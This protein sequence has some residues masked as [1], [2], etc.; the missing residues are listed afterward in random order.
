M[1]EPVKTFS[2]GFE[3]DAGVRRNR[4]RAARP[5]ERFGT[6]HTEFRVQPSAIDLLDTLIWHHDG[7]FGDS[8]AIP[9][10]LVSQAD[11]RARHRR[12][13][14]RRRRRSVCR[15]PAVRRRDCRRSQCPA[16]AAG[17]AVT[18]LP[19]AAGL[20]QRAA[21]ESRAA[22]ASR[23]SCSCRWTIG[24]RAWTGVFFDDLERLLAGGSSRAAPPS[25]ARAHLRVTGRHRLAVDRRSAVCSR[26][27]S[28][29]T[30]TTICW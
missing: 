29:A 23:A 30:C 5:R 10:Y 1:T 17:A 24:S 2:I 7:P 16:A 19:T 9:T 25:I 22:A 15:L 21:L 18:A 8:S 4:G 13:D 11:A 12:A 28:T 27:T 26:P 20:A 3:G 14:R 6:E